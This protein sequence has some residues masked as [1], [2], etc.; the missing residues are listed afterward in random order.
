MQLPIW[1]VLTVWLRF[2]LSHQDD[3]AE[4]AVGVPQREAVGVHQEA[5]RALKEADQ[6]HKEE[7]DKLGQTPEAGPEPLKK[8]VKVAV[9]PI[10]EATRVLMAEVAVDEAEDVETQ[11]R[12]AVEVG[13][14]MVAGAVIKEAALT[15]VIKALVEAEDVEE[16]MTEEEAM[17][18]EEV[19]A[20]AGQTRCNETREGIKDVVVQI[21]QAGRMDVMVLRARTT[22]DMEQTTADTALMDLNLRV[23][24]GVIQGKR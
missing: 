20:G 16:A 23:L 8:V 10:R 18:E 15:L 2:R 17:A 24:Q 13:I 22:V 7:V 21:R 6:V 12:G 14:R 11:I 5:E 1:S 9:E 3:R 4:E 19:M